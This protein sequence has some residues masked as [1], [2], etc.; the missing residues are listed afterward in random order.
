MV[1]Q[2]YVA[3]NVN[4]SIPITN[5]GTSAGTA[6]VRSSLV[7]PPSVTGLDL[8]DSVSG[9]LDGVVTLNPVVV[10]LLHFTLRFNH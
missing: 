4:V 8:S 3:E 1:I 9:A 7:L 6:Y 10:S 2:K 5:I